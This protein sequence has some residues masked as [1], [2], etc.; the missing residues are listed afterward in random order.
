[1]FADDICSRHARDGTWTGGICAII[2]LT[3]IQRLIFGYKFQL[4]L[5]KNTARMHRSAVV[6]R[7]VIGV[8]PWLRSST[9][10]TSLYCT[11]SA[12]RSID[13][14]CHGWKTNYIVAIF[15]SAAHYLSHTLKELMTLRLRA[16]QVATPTPPTWLRM[17]IV[18]SRIAWPVHTW[19]SHPYRA[20]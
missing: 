8:I 19:L 12:V 10:H 7:L 6:R 11:L 16:F 4:P 13:A 3:S 1:M 18:P 17:P 9:G 5:T 20:L 15:H 2:P 14:P